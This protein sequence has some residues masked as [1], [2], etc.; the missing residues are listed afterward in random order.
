METTKAKLPLTDAQR[1]V[2]DFIIE[3]MRENQCPP[4]IRDICERFDFSSPN[5]A[6]FHIEVLEKKGWITR[7]ADNK[8]RGI[9]VMLD[10]GECPFCGLAPIRGESGEGRR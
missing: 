10:S 8:A 4:T 9:R 2:F 1:A 3:Y 7:S 6:M 5:G